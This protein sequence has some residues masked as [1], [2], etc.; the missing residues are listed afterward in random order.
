MGKIYNQIIS[1]ISIGITFLAVGL[2]IQGCSNESNDSLQVKEQKM[3]MDKYLDCA[4]S[5][6]I[7]DKGMKVLS[8]VFQRIG[9]KLVVD[10]DTCYLT[11]YSAKDLNI[12]NY[13]F[14][15]VE[16]SVDNANVQYQMYQFFEKNNK[17]IVVKNPFDINK[18]VITTR[19]SIESDYGNQWSTN[20]YNLSHTE[21]TTVIN[22]MRTSNGSVSTFGSIVAGVFSGATASII[23]GLYGYFN[24]SQFSNIQDEYARSGATKGI[25]LRESTMYS[26][27]GIS[28]TSYGSSINR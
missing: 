16:K 7:S 6:L 15:L 24:D 9:N 25:T 26:P 10:N 18:Q 21:V 5:D 14:S 3:G 28:H 20:T 27:T 17:G 12:S 23:V 13:L 4:E 11:V 2:S 8:E 1:C 19:V 22:A